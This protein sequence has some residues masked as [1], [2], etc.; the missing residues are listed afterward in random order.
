M[1]AAGEPGYL[2]VCDRRSDIISFADSDSAALD[3]MLTH[4]NAAIR[5]QQLLTQIRYDADHD[6]LTGLPNRQRLA[7]EI[8]QLLSADPVAARAGLILAAL[9]NY[10]E[11]TDTLGHAASDELLLVTAGLLREHAPPAALLARMEGEQ[12][13]VLLPGL[14]LRPPSVPPA[15]SGRPPPRGP[16]WRAWTW[17]SR[18]RS[19]W[20][21][22]RCTAPTP[23]CSC[24]G[25]TSRC[26]PR[27]TPAASPAT[28]PC[29]TSRASAGCNWAPSSS[30]RWPTG[31]SAWSSSRSSTRRAPTSSRSRRWSAGR[32]RA[33]GRSRRTTSSTSPSRSAASARSPTTCSTSPW[34]AAG[35]GW[36]RTSRCR[37]RSTC[38]CTA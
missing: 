34:P 8:D 37:S 27:A 33:T 15:G 36:T 13:A 26:S 14:S 25:P 12:F 23:A 35:A 3:S 22:L 11:V 21:R 1:T 32:T 16:G 20:P 30:R 28:T 24:S 29:S 7:A 4:V 10:T 6:R 5:H 38:P 19:A 2:E 9:G 18:S 17:R 31:R